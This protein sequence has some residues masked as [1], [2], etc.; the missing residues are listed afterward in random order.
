MGGREAGLLAHQLPGYRFVVSAEHRREVE[1]YWNLPP[2]S[3]SK[4]PGLTAVEMFR[5][6]ESGKLKAVWIAATNPAAS[7]PDLHQA[8]RALSRAELVIVQDIHHPTETTRFAHVLL[9]AANWVEKEGTSTNSERTV[10]FSERLLAP[11]GSAR[12]DWEIIASVGRA[13][14]YTGFDYV[15]RE[16]VWDEFVRLTAGRPC[17]MSGMTAAR[18]REVKSLQW[19]CPSADHP[20]AKRRYLDRKFPTANTRARL[21]AHPYRPPRE[22]ADAEFPMTLTTGRIYAHWHTLTRTGKSEKLLMRDGEPYVELHPDDAERLGVREGDDVSLQSRRGAIRL[23][24]RLSSSLQ[25][26]TLFAPFHWGDLWGEDRAVNYLTLA[27]LDPLSKQPELKF[28]AVV[29]EAATGTTF[30]TL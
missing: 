15:G 24:A 14:G 19:P 1:T 8:R 9:P 18:L 26:G 12:P 29:A 7:L 16:A 30:S 28:C 21:I 11:P 4:D 17:D 25:P 2:D 13:L 23:P 6:L 20:G 27:A 3:I 22:A 5:G 10:A